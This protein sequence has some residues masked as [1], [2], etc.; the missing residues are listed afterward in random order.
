MGWWDLWAE[1]SQ[2]LVRGL[3]GREGELGPPGPHAAAQL[4]AV[5]L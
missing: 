3:W 2:A 1:Q 5:G 4:L